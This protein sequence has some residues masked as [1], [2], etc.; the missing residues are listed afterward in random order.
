MR[1]LATLTFA[2]V[3]ALAGCSSTEP[4]PAG[5]DVAVVSSVN[6]PLSLPGRS[7]VAARS[8]S[9]TIGPLDILTFR[10]FSLEKA[11]E[12]S[13]FDLE[14]DG[15]GSVFVPFAGLIAVAGK[16]TGEVR[17]LVIERLSANVL[18]NPQVTV[19]VKDF[20]SQSI[21]VLG[22]V[23]KGGSF[24]LQ[25]NSL[26]LTEALALAGGPSARVGTRAIVLVPPVGDEA[27]R[28]IDVDLVA[29]LVD[30]DSN[31]D[32]K[33]GSHFSVN[34]LLAEDF[35]VV[36]FVPHPG[37]FPYHRPL[38]VTQA[39]GLAGGVDEKSGSSSTIE[40]TRPTDRGTE[41]LLVDLTEIA[42]GHAPDI[43]VY[44]RDSIA[45]RR[46]FGKALIEFIEAV[47]SHFGFGY[48]L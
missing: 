16:S 14:V 39:I 21:T 5:R 37:N 17:S 7:D 13:T 43:A 2:A 6:A 44:P 47:T 24:Y 26:T 1:P 45:V 4:A 30:G 11:R 29:L 27:P 35:Y 46:T 10:I 41:L 25:K 34:V 12:V 3:L 33:I 38:T 40:I 28:R 48:Q 31:W 32:V 15:G 18:L 9:Y 22:A 36:G 23:E 42:A 20:R 8:A 19:T